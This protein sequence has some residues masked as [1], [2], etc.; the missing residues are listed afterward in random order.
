MAVSVTGAQTDVNDNISAN[1]D[2]AVAAA[3]NLRLLGFAYR[4]RAGT[5]AA[6]A[7][8]IVHGATVAGGTTLVPVE[9]AANESGVV[10]FGEPGLAAANGLSIAVEAGTLD[11]ELFY[12]TD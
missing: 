3:P 2:A 8:R 5:P 4:E 7:F 1:V 6:A 11:V 10:W 9:V 12:R